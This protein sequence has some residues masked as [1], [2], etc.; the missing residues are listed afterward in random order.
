MKEQEWLASNDPYKMLEFIFEQTY[1]KLYGLKYKNKWIL[2]QRKL[3]LYGCAVFKGIIIEYPEYNESKDI[4]NIVEQFADGI[5]SSDYVDNINNNS[6]DNIDPYDLTYAL[7]SR[8]DHIL[9]SYLKT[10]FDVTTK[11]K[12]IQSDLLRDIVGNPWHLDLT[13]LDIPEKVKQIILNIYQEQ[14]WNAIPILTDMLEDNNFNDDDILYHLRCR[15]LLHTKG[16]WAID[17]LLN[18]D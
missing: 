9:M 10:F 4:I 5:L 6:I 14:D 12:I 8:N 11:R 17:K 7:T 2:S 3:I 16:C 15:N 18:K 1:R 13:T